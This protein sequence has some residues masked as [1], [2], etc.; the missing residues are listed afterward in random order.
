MTQ[1]IDIERFRAQL[2]GSAL[3][4]GDV[5]YDEARAAWNGAIDRYPAVIVRCAGSG[6]VTR[7]IRLGRERGL[8]ISVRGGFHNAAGRAICDDGLMIDLSP[9]RDVSVDPVARQA[10][11]GGGATVGDLD[12][13]TQKYGLA[14]P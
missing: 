10:R 3:T 2:A 6:D 8:D 12:A 14:T 4:R 11:A 5:G 7:A 9:M 1:T 13:A